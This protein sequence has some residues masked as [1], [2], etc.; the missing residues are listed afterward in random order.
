MCSAVIWIYGKVHLKIDDLLF[1]A[2]MTSAWFD[3]VRIQVSKLISTVLNFPFGLIKIAQQNAHGYLTWR[4]FEMRRFGN[5]VN[6]EIHCRM[7]LFI[8]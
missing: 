6:F 1:L 4:K 3:I 5:I 2:Q 8:R 7:I